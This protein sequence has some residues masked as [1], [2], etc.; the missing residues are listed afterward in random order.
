MDLGF[1]RGN[2]IVTNNY[3]RGAN[4]LEQRRF[5][6]SQLV[7]NSPLFTGFASASNYPLG[8]VSNRTQVRLPSQG[9]DEGISIGYLGVDYGFFKTIG[10][11]IVEGRDFN[12]TYSTDSVSAV[13][14]NQQL[15]KRIGGV[16]F[17]IGFI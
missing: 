10:A 12:K 8:P 16:D 14:I 4:S 17:K 7:Q 2:L 1:E 5:L 3:L 6:A 15:A 13:I 11:T 9:S